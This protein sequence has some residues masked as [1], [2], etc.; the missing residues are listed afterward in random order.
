MLE[1]FDYELLRILWWLILGILLIGFAIMDG[2][3]LGVAILLPFVGKN[4]I[5]R[6]TILNSIGPFWEGNQVWFI[7]GGVSIFAAWPHVYAVTFSGFYFAMLLVLLAFILRP[8]G[9]DYRS[10]IEHKIWR[11]IWDYCIFISGFVPSLV[12]GIAVG[13]AIKGIPFSFNEF[14]VIE[15]QISFFGLLTPFTLLCGLLSVTMIIT[16]GASYLA[17]KTEGKI[18]ERVRFII[19]II[20]FFTIILFAAGGF[21]LQFVDCYQL[22]EFAGTNAASNPL[23]KKVLKLKGCWYDNYQRHNWMMIAPALGFLGQIGLL[24]F[25]HMKQ[26]GKAFI[27]SSFSILGI[28]STVGLTLFPFLL[29]SSLDPNSSLII[30]DSSSSK[31]TLLIM[32]IAAICLIPIVLAYTSWVY[33]I[34][35]G[36]VKEK[37]V[38]KNSKFLY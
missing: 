35:R 27:S 4:D 18:Q 6:R 31:A 37:D 19:K 20:P 1:L 23:T 16:Q 10:K 26:Y 24:L 29:P 9:F 28:I 7:L 15:N 30:W 34:M 25:S 11:R 3:D 32:L 36:K 33:H 22:Q 5:E 12:F 2:F 8:V 13:N 38:V 14:M 21:L 17:I